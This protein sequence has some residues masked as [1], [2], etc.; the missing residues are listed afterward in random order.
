MIAGK[1]PNKRSTGEVKGLCA[2][3]GFEVDITWDE[4]VLVRTVIRSKLG[5]PC[6]V[7]YGDERLRFATE[8]G[9]ER[10]VARDAGR[11]ILGENLK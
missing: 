3:G 5:K 8:T 7:R 9:D 6:V 4:A 2:R 10:T 1:A 11:L